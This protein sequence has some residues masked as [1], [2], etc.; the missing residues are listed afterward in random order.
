MV[1]SADMIV[2]YLHKANIIISSTFDNHSIVLSIYFQEVMINQSTDKTN[3][4]QIILLLND[5]ESIPDLDYINFT[6]PEELYDS[7]FA[8]LQR[9]VN[10]QAL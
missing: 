3:K 7:V 2:N 1:K 5:I 6:I 8:L 10:D 9:I 4:S